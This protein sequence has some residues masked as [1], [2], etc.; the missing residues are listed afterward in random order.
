MLRHK[1]FHRARKI[2]VPENELK[3][4]KKKDK[5]EKAKLKSDE[6]KSIKAKEEEVAAADSVAEG[7]KTDK[8][9]K[10]VYDQYWKTA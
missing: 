10:K 9:S 3:S 4:K 6:K 5:E 2:V 8:E 1:L 7:E